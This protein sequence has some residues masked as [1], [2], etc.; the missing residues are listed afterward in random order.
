MTGNCPT[1]G[2]A[3]T[4]KDIIDNKYPDILSKHGEILDTAKAVE[5]SNTLTVTSSRESQYAAEAAKMT[6]ESYA[7]APVGEFVKVYTSNGDGTFSSVEQ[8]TYSALHYGVSTAEEGQHQMWLAEAEKMTAKSYAEELHGVSVKKYTSNGDGTFSSEPVN[9]FSALH[10]AEE[11]LAKSGAVSWRESKTLTPGQIIVGFSKNINNASVFK[12]GKLLEY[13]V[14][15]STILKDVRLLRTVATGDVVT[16]VGQDAT[17]GNDFL[18]LRDEAEQ[19]FIWARRERW[20]AEAE[21]MTAKSAANEAENTPT[22]IFTSNG[23]GTFSFTKTTDRSAYHWSRKIGLAMKD[24]TVVDTVADFAV[25]NVNEVNAVYAKGLNVTYDG[26]GGLFVYDKSKG[27]INDKYRIIDGFV[28]QDD[29]KPIGKQLSAFKK[30]GGQLENL[31][32]SLSNPLEQFTSISFIGDS[33]TWGIGILGGLPTDPRVGGLKDTR[34]GYNEANYVNRIKWYIRDTFFDGDAGVVGNWSFSMG[35]ESNVTYTKRIELYPVGDQFTVTTVGATSTVTEVVTTNAVF[36]RRYD[37]NMATVN[38]YSTLSFNFTGTEFE[39]FFTSLSITSKYEIIVDGVSQ[40]VF[41]TDLGVI[42]NQ[43][44]RVHTFGYVRDKLVEI[45]SV[46]NTAKTGVQSL[47]IEAIAIN[48]KVLI[49]NQGVS[50]I[51]TERYNAYNFGLLGPSVITPETNYVF[52]Q[53]G[54]NDRVK[55]TDVTRGMGITDYEKNMEALLTNIGTGVDVILMNANMTQDFN[56]TTFDF[57]ESDIKTSVHKLAKKHSLD[58]I[59]NYSIFRGVN[60]DIALNDGLHPS[61]VGHEMIAEN[62]ISALENA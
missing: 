62:I 44:S 28:R 37:F 8:Q 29:G 40:G 55:K 14:E 13:G 26:Y 50:G 18:S 39:L 6:S 32:T 25:L 47:Q 36:D 7:I 49:E 15:Y 21:K 56:A 38:D 61:S 2:F 48:K 52:V 24:V 59:N 20:I 10:Y 34:A 23:D 35:G 42:A 57:H 4:A 12:N 9:T 5:D 17:T 16:V 58:W 27:A 60:L 43:Q 3:A 54:T 30:Y 1:G 22:K 41:D 46:Y 45:K 19:Q 11:A 31:Y 53:L 33:I 51:T